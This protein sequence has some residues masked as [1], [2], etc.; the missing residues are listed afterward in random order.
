MPLFVRLS[1]SN[2]SFHTYQNI[3]TYTCD[4]SFKLIGE[5]TR[6]CLESGKWSG[7]APTC[8]LISE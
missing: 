2:I 3:A 5:C 1:L 7:D 8:S 4:A 6:V